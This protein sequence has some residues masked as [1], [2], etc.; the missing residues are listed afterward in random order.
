MAGVSRTIK[1]G[2]V[3]FRISFYNKDG[4]RKFVRLTNVNE[5][6]AQRIAD[7]IDLLVAA[8]IDGGGIGGDLAAWVRNAGKDL[9]EKLERVGLLAPQE[10]KEPSDPTLKD[11]LDSY[12][13][14]RHDVKKGTSINY[15][16]V[17]KDLINFFSEERRIGTITPGDADEFRR[18]LLK[19]LSDNTV[20]R[21]CGRAR[22]FFRAAERK[23][24]IEGNPFDM[25]NLTVRGNRERDYYVTP[26]QAAAV[27]E[28]CPDNEWRLIF[29]LCR[30]AGLRCPSEH[31]ALKWGDIDWHRNRIT[32]TS[33]KTEHY[34]GGECR[35][36][37]M[38]P[39]LREHL[40]FAWDQPRDSEY[41]ITRYRDA[42]ANLRTQFQRIITRAGIT[43]WPKL[44]QNL[45]AS[46]AT[47]LASRFPAHV[48]AEWMGHSVAVAAKHYLQ[49][50][51]SHYEAAIAPQCGTRGGTIAAPNMARGV[52]PH[53]KA[54][55]GTNSPDQ[56]KT[57][58][59]TG[60]M[61]RSASRNKLLQ[62]Y[63]VT[64]VG[65][66][67]TTLALKVPYSTN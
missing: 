43:P 63:L 30:F 9:Q 48:A 25:K 31:L 27:L 59:D 39:E 34:E 49:T 52:A 64:R 29:A 58:A 28:A 3:R 12:T 54:L 37:P 4:E 32:I 21:R 51:D 65:L 5:R 61:L 33:P 41:V 62:N 38:F 44:F 26:E 16:I 10:K 66:E 55:S 47:D 56:Q 8:S 11:F 46:M 2:Q 42:N 15:G 45:R 13:S 40:E 1:D 14:S 24:L 20:R 18:H 60:E 53:G 22:Q 7:K 35:V 6:S 57:P 50:L 67:P 17:V 36:I 19:R 23:R